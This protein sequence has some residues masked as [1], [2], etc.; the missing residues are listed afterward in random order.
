MYVLWEFSTGAKYV[1]KPVLCVCRNPCFVCVETRAC[2]SKP[3]PV[4]VETRACVCRNP[5]LFI[6]LDQ[7][8]QNP[9]DTHNVVLNVIALQEANLYQSI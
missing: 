9:F 5:C 2:V 4:C 8:N 3:V 6:F 7:G 1:S